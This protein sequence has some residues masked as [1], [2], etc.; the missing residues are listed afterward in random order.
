MRPG[1]MQ[2]RTA[3]WRGPTA[4]SQRACLPAGTAL[5]RSFSTAAGRQTSLAAELEKGPTLDDFVQGGA[6]AAPR[7]RLRPARERKPEWLKVER[8]TGDNYQRLRK[9]LRSL[10]LATVCEEARCPNIGECWGGKE[11]T[12]TA[13]I[14]VMGDTCT[15]ACRFCNVKTAKAPGALD[16]MEPANT[17]DAIASWDINYVVITSVDRDD[18]PDAGAA[19]L[20]S[21]IREIKARKPSL[22][23]ECLAPDFSGVEALVGQV[24]R[25]GLNVFAHNIETV[26]RLQGRVRDRRANYAQSL[27]VLEAARRLQPGLVTKSSIMLGVGEEAA[28]VRQAMR[29]LLSAGVEIF[30]LGQYLRPS[31]KHMPVARM[32]TPEEYEAWRQEGMD[33][34]FKYVASGPLVRS[35]YR[36]G[37][38]F[39]EAFARERQGQAAQ[40]AA[41]QPA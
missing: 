8:P 4:R 31:K 9:S 37:E 17:A 3:M 14:M 13:T 40:T 27:S 7:S 34:G 5:G 20:A 26:E 22:M 28:E 15:R 25:A 2:W 39:L 29:D 16:P 33:M 38:F 6:A 19:H 11:G 35:S 36:A 18:L 24:A 41:A 12:A 10:N 1:V 21:V 32:L 23:L 30:T